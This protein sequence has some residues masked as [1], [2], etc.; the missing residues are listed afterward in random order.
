MVGM[1]RRAERLS[2]LLQE[3]ISDII[4]TR[5]KDPRIGFATVMR[6]EISEDLGYL[7]AYISVY[8]GDEEKRRTIEGLESAKGFVRGEIGRRVRMKRVPEISFLL[9]DSLSEAFRIMDIM[10]DLEKE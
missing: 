1:Y 2:K 10:K 4:K 9:D 6:V 7:K 8:G 3:E 5:L